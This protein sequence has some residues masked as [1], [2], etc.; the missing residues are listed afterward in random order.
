MSTQRNSSMPT[1]L[2][3]IMPRYSQTNSYSVLHRETHPF[4]IPFQST[5]VASL[6]ASLTTPFRCHRSLA[7]PPSPFPTKAGKLVSYVLRTAYGI[8]F[9]HGLKIKIKKL[10][11]SHPTFS[12]GSDQNQIPHVRAQ[13]TPKPNTGISHY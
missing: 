13:R 7:I 3:T 2:R 5:P 12:Q 1:L 6:A 10:M 9:M 8:H 4:S 11:P